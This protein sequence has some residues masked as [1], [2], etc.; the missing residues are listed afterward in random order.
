MRRTTPIRPP[1]RGT[2]AAQYIRIDRLY[3]RPAP[4][5]LHTQFGEE[6]MA[7]SVSCD[8]MVDPADAT[9]KSDV[10]SAK[11]EGRTLELRQG[12]INGVQ[13][14]WAR[15]TDAKNGDAIWLEISGDGGET[16]IKCGRRTLESGQR[17]YTDAQ[18]TSSS[19]DVCMRAA[20]QLVGPNY[21]TASWC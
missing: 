18:R 12:L 17:N 6:E 19:S 9:A 13:Y 1:F 10:E 3:R 8:G 4:A 20:T 2:F 16:W 15:L 7:V 14:C 5:I 21:R 11:V